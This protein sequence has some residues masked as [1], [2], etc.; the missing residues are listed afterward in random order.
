MSSPDGGMD[1]YHLVLSVAAIGACGKAT[2]HYVRLNP[3]CLA[4]EVI[5]HEF[6]HT[7]GLD[8]LYNEGKYPRAPQCDHRLVESDSIMFGVRR[9]TDMD[10][11]Q[12]RL[13]WGLQKTSDFLVS[14]PEVLPDADPTLLSPPG[15]LPPPQCSATQAKTTGLTQLRDLDGG[16]ASA[17][18]TQLLASSCTSCN[19]LTRSTSVYDG[20][21]VIDGNVQKPWVS[22]DGIDPAT[23]VFEFSLE[24]DAAVANAISVYVADRDDQLKAVRLEYRQFGGGEEG[25]VALLER[26]ALESQL[27][28]SCQ[29]GTQY[30]G[31]THRPRSTHDCATGVVIGRSDAGVVL[32]RCDFA[33]PVCID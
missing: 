8:D 30:F 29:G 1:H 4:P 32:D 5:T 18:S 9:L 11:Y 15:G 27:H 25:F 10:S 12:L 24:P 21:Y 23:L 19:S 14:S 20:S 3:D 7:F 22:E 2:P 6:G 16:L 26:D 13:V 33:L 17:Q 31:H 28:A